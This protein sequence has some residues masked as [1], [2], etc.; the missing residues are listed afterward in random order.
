M[1]LHVLQVIT[2]ATGATELSPT[3]TLAQ[4]T[5]AHKSVTGSEMNRVINYGQTGMRIVY[6]DYRLRWIPIL[7]STTA[8][9]EL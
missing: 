9:N 4:T 8:S 7:R 1:Q 5:H 2:T 3:Q 6:Q